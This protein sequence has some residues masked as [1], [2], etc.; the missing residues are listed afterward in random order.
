MDVGLILQMMLRSR[1]EAI[2]ALKGHAFDILVVGGGITGSGVARDA[3]L[4]GLRVALVEQDDFASGTSSRSSRLVHGGV[5]YLEHGH[6]RLVFESSAERRLLL[7]LAP[8][9]VRPL[10]FTWPVYEGARIARWKLGAGLALYDA[11]ALFRN[12]GR[13]A[14]LARNAV[15]AREPRLREDHLLGGATYYDAS[16]DDARLTLANALDAAAQG[17]AVAN[18]VRADE[19]LDGTRGEAG[20]VVT[21]VL[22]GETFTVRARVVVRAVGPWTG[23]RVRGSTG[24][25]VSVPRHRLGNVAAL[26]LSAPQDGR[27]MFA[28][29]AGAFAIIGTTESPTTVP[30]DEVRATEAD[31]AYLLE[32]ANHYFPEARLTRDDVVS[33]WAGVRPLVASSGTLGSA[34]REHAVTTAGRV[35]TVTGGKLTTYRVMADDV[36]RAAGRVLGARLP[37]TLT[38]TRPLPGGDVGDIELEQQRIERETGLPAPTAEWLVRA[39]GSRWPH[40]RGAMFTSGCGDTRLAAGLPYLAAEVAHAVTHEMAMTIGDVLVRRTHAAFEMADQARALAPQVAALMAPLLGWDAVRERA[41]VERYRADA[42]RM[43]RI[44]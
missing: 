29:P 7:R 13:H 24:V 33:A 4:R 19:I 25:H 3:A 14:R 22:T 36:V 40:V 42:D 5:R 16:T 20:A 6:L 26:T 38:R 12:V 17:A 1:A 27:V 35:V 34:S 32:A 37:R 9:L 15:M 39:Y 44:G 23:K 30:P 21:D 28:L 2:A 31:V 18:H 8:H 43:F 11:L 41:E 10:Q